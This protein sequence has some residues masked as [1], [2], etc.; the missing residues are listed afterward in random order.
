MQVEVRNQNPRYADLEY[1][2]PMSLQQAE[3]ML[4]DQT[5]L[6]EY[7]IG[8]TH[9]FLFSITNKEVHSYN[10]PGNRKLTEQVL[11]IRES[12]QNPNDNGYRNISPLLYSELVKPAE[13][14]LNGKTHVLIAPDGPLNYLPFE[15]L[16]THDKMGSSAIPF[17]ALQ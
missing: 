7:F 9:S 1:P 17:L 8:E 10:L 11:R 2:Q 15:T 13:N 5:I 4:D 12:L 14:Q 16:I 3:Q 6:L